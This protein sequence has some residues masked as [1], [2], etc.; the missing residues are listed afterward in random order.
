MASIK[1]LL[2]W[3][4]K[5]EDTPIAPGAEVAPEVVGSP[6]KKSKGDY[7][8]EDDMLV[9]VTNYAK[10]IKTRSEFFA[11]FDAVK[12][13]YLVDAIVS[14]MVEDALTE[15]AASDQIVEIT[16]PI[17]EVNE[18]LK[19]LQS[20]IDFDLLAKDIGEELLYNGEYFLENELE[21]GKGVTALRDSVDSKKAVC[22]YSEGLPS[23]YLIFEEDKQYSQHQIK[24]E[25][26]YKYAH[27]TFSSQ[28][29]KLDLKAM[30]G[31]SE[32]P[33]D[34]PRHTRV[35]KPFFYGVVHKI[36]ELHLLESLIPAAK[37]SEI[38]QGNLVGVNLPNN[39]DP[40]KAFQTVR[41]YE[42]TLN[43]NA[44]V[45]PT[46]TGMSVQDIL[47]QAAKLKV[48]PIFGEKGNLQV[49]GDI[50]SNSSVNDLLQSAK[51]TRDLITSSLGFP[52]ELLF[53]GEGTKGEVLKRY[54][55]YLRKLKALQTS[56]GNGF[57][58]VAI[59]H[60][61]NSG[62]RP[63]DF[64]LNDIK[65]NFMNEFINIDELEKLEFADATLRT[66]KDTVEF[67]KEMRQDQNFGPFV[68]M[69]A[70]HRWLYSTMQLMHA[71]DTF[72]KNPPEMDDDT[73]DYYADHSNDFVP[74]ED[75]GA[76]FE[77]SAEPFE[78]PE[79]TPAPEE[80]EVTAAPA[81]GELPIGVAT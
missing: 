69:G 44:G 70:V 33:E 3:R 12:S 79:E 54:A 45:D 73:A 67:I 46:K 28:K 8:K 11:E 59:V 23:K 75:D 63:G 9:L 6:N 15:D 7:L 41:K 37:I 27:F 32:F 78:E 56:I 62:F 47:A 30:Y 42:K 34:F 74:P 22:L 10:I 17:E 43:A 36:K 49:L 13:F 38:M 16:S 2:F 51:D 68:D 71:G 61:L 5:S 50:R 77:P 24:V 64:D 21:K 14:Q 60:L 52:S 25:A 65:V 4:S 58:Q 39:T 76:E 66:I 31:K 35:G 19:K 57:K 80:P 40:E 72:I 81:P 53:S 55:R 48:L 1:S 20:R 29:I 26:A 18:S